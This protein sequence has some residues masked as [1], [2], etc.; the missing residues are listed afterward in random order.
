M[1][2]FKNSLD[3]PTFDQTKDP[4]IHRRAKQRNVTMYESLR[5]KRQDTDRN[6]CNAIYP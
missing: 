2:F 1:H 5:V 3:D 6:G 4:N